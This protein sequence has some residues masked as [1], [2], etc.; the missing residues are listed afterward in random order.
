VKT[1]E[2]ANKDYIDLSN[3]PTTKKIPTLTANVKNLISR[4][5]DQE[6]TMH[7]I[8]LL[9]QKLPGCKDRVGLYD[10]VRGILYKMHYAGKLDKIHEGD[11]NNYGGGEP[12][13]WRAV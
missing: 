9:T 12:S 5:G 7:Q 3:I 6:F 1:V 4:V 13:V 10:T 11:C 2:K 8:F